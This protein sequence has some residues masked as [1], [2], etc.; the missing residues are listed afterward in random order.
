MHRLAIMRG[1]LFL[2]NFAN[3]GVNIETHVVYPGRA[4]LQGRDQHLLNAVQYDLAGVAAERI[5]KRLVVRSAMLQEP[6]QLFGTS[7]DVFFDA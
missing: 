4:M 3:R 2:K 1:A 6:L 5:A 7:E